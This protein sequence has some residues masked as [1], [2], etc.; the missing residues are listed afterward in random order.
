MITVVGSLNMDLVTKTDKVPK[1]GET[2]LGVEFK[3]AAGGKGANQADAIAKLGGKVA[4]IGRV[5]SDQF[6]KTLIESLKHD[7]V[8]VSQ[9]QVTEGIS[10]GIATIIVNGDGDN[11]I[12]VVSG[13]NFKLIPQDIDRAEEVIKE[14][15][16]MIA[17][18]EVPIGV[19]KYAFK[20]AKQYGKYTVLNPAPARELDQELLELTDLLVPNETELEILSGRT[21]VTKDDMLVAAKELMQKGVKE[22]IV[23]LGGNGC[24]H[25]NK[26]SSNHYP[27]HL[28]EA[29]DTTA[30]GDSFI[31]AIATALSEGKSIEAAIHFAAKVSALTVTREGAQDSLPTKK[32]V[33]E[34][35]TDI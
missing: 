34:Y 1:V 23:T 32:E 11:S 19:I 7:G 5:G 16:I 24:L 28:V 17:Q 8:E 2:F 12:I 14:S 10:T 29:V 27:A 26:T 31:G 33:E 6:G 21:L 9:V 22:M 35:M 18:L 13:A 4:M 15:A 20:K 25:I 3:Q 30:A